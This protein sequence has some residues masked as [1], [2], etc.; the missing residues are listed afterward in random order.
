MKRQLTLFNKII[1]SRRKLTVLLLN[2]AG[3]N[4]DGLLVKFQCMVDPM[5]PKFPSLMPNIKR[6]KRGKKNYSNSQIMNLKLFLCY[7]TLGLSYILAF[8]SIWLRQLR[9]RA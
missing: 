9:T 1:L 3:E 7:E 2:V 4:H 6:L 5:Q 8:F